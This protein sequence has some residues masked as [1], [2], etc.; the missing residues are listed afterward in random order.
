MK[1]ILLK[2]KMRVENQTKTRLISVSRKECEFL[3]TKPAD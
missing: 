3:C 2:G 1:S